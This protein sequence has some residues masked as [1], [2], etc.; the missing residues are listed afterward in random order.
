MRYAA[1]PKNID[2]GSAGNAAM[3][4]VNREKDSDEG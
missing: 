3:S 1:T 4:E 2:I